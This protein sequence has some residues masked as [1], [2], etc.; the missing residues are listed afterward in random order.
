MKEKILE[1]MPLKWSI[2]A[3]NV[4]Y[5]WCEKNENS[6]TFLLAVKSNDD[7]HILAGICYN[8]NKWS[9]QTITYNVTNSGQ[10]Y[11]IEM[12]SMLDL[13]KYSL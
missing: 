3:A 13:C 9:L 8:L 5:E 11:N 10:K 2:Y 4:T 1:C 12:V 7:H 6:K